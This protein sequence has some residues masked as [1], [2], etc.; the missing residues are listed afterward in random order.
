MIFNLQEE[1]GQLTR[2]LLT[3]KKVLDWNEKYW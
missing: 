1:N 3:Q 2:K